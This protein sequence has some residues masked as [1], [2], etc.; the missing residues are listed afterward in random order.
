ML[1]IL[2]T[3]SLGW[4][5]IHYAIHYPTPTPLVQRLLQGNPELTQIKDDPLHWQAYEHWKAKKIDFS[6]L[7]PAEKDAYLLL[8][9]AVHNKAIPETVAEILMYSMPYNVSG[10]FNANHCDTWTY[11]MAHC[12]DAYW[13]SIDIVLT[14]YEH[15][16][17]V[18][19][20]LAEFQDQ[21]TQRCID[22]S[23][24]RSLHE[25]LR[26]MYFF[27]RYEMHKQMSIHAS[28]HCLTHSAIFHN[29]TFGAVIA[30]N[31]TSLDNF[32]SD[33]VNSTAS[34]GVV[35]KFTNFRSKF[36]REIS[37]RTLNSVPVLDS[38]FIV[39]LLA[40]HNA[41]EDLKYASEIQLKG[42]SKYPFL[43]V[44]KQ[45]DRDLNAITKHEHLE[46][47]D[48]S[49][50]RTYIKQLL[51]CLRYL[52]ETAGIVHGDIKRELLVLLKCVQYLFFRSIIQGYFYVLHFVG[53]IIYIV[54]F[55]F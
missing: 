24:P 31:P 48:M 44:C 4:R 37:I 38:Q 16:Q 2:Y 33:P 8:H 28:K 1:L 20:K 30:N 6:P 45:G 26:R 35:L 14:A 34:I 49:T 27:S 18:I 10:K 9:Y 43:L 29:T 22:I 23:S 21:T 51:Q 53:N 5:S 47:S 52:H 17:V 3:C 54:Y 40:Y 36:I 50:V 42:F 32:G 13:R 7:V 15:D 11:V 25:I 46:G 55:I 19:N 39:P 12:C 41:Q